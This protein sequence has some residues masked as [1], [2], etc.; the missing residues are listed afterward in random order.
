MECVDELSQDS[1]KYFNYMRQVQKQNYAKQQYLAKRVSF[2]SVSM[3]SF[4]TGSSLS[5]YYLPW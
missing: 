4:E 1:N 5:T 3:F 2:L